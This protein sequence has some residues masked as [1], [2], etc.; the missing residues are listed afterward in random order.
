[1]ICPIYF[2]AF[3]N[4]MELAELNRTQNIVDLQYHEEGMISCQVNDISAI[5]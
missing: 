4:I 5:F 3:V 2:L 1:M